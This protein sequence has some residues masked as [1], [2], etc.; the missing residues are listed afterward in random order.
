M[1]IA[2][3]TSR[4]SWSLLVSKW[5]RRMWCIYSGIV[6]HCAFSMV[7]SVLDLLF[8]LETRTAGVK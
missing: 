6:C 7:S 4:S 8:G 2:R 1:S 5:G 3:P